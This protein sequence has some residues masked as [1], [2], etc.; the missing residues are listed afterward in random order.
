MPEISM[1]AAVWI[2]EESAW[3]GVRRVCGMVR[4]DVRDVTGVLPEITGTPAVCK[5]AVI[6]GTLGRSAVLDGLAASGKLNASA[7][8]GKWEVYSFQAV[9]HPLPGVDRA[10]II[11]GSDK[12][13]TIYGLFHLSEL[14]GV[15]PLKDWADVP[16][17]R[18]NR[19]T[20]T[21]MDDLISRE[22]SV[23]SFNRSSL[24]AHLSRHGAYDR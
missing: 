1:T 11:A 3:P 24:S 7:I 4:E 15:S 5:D 2:L 13:G 8:R 10:L 16:P 18:R 9:E 20:V 22:P 19:V 12:R 6:V 14:M 17:P 21:G 23:Y